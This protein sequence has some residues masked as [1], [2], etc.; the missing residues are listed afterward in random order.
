MLSAV[1]PVS[2]ASFLPLLLLPPPPPPPQA[3]R[4]VATV[5]AAT[6][7]TRRRVDLDNGSPLCRPGLD[8]PG[9]LDGGTTGRD[10]VLTPRSLAGTDGP[11]RV[12]TGAGPSRR[13][14]RGR[15]S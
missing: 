8:W 5:A 2:E 9:S 1:T 11:V 3:A 15:R 7:V 6:K 13:S 14:R 4:V 10:A 12:P